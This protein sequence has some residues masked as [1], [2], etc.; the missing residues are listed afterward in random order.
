MLAP[1]PNNPAGVSGSRDEIDV[2]LDAIVSGS[3]IDEVET[4]PKELVS[5][6]AEIL[7]APGGTLTVTLSAPERVSGHDLTLARAGL[8]RRSRETPAR[9]D[10]AVHPTSALPG[11]L[12]RLTAI[13]PVEPLAEDVTLDVDATVVDSLFDAEPSTRHAAWSTMIEAST[14]L[15]AAMRSEL[16]QAPPRAARLVRHRPGGDRSATVVLLRGR[17]LLAEGS[18]LSALHG[19]S[20][21]GAVRSLMTALLP[22]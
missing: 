18:A 6:L 19:S 15:P 13:S 20:P 4:L 11:L 21:T 1:D 17:Y 7:R 16:E 2:F 10:L 8:L 5:T 9:E 14:A 22:R 3:A 12:L